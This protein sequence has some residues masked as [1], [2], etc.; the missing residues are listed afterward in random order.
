MEP[1][2]Q[3]WPLLAAALAIA[4]AWLVFRADNFARMLDR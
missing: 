3:A 2:S 1:L 4:T